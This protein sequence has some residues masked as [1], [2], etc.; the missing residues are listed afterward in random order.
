MRQRKQTSP[1]TPEGWLQLK[2][3]KAAEELKLGEVS[4]SQNS[5]PVAKRFT[6][7]EIYELVERANGNTK[8]ICAALDCTRS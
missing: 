7:K 8:A 5:L 1:S 4:S 6:L 3:A 2:M